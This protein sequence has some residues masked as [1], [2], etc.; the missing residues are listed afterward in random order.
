[1]TSIQATTTS[2]GWKSG[3]KKPTGS[4]AKDARC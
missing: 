1:M 2:T 3:W 4:N